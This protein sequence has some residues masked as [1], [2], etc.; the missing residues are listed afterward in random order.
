MTGPAVFDAAA[1][2]AEL[3]A[4]D[5]KVYLAR[6]GGTAGFPR[7]VTYSIGSPDGRGFGESFRIVMGRWH[8][9]M[10]ACPDHVGQVVAHLSAMGEA[11]S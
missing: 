8:D 1:F 3:V 10:E 7:R 2:V 9:A 4:L 6:A 11:S 5:C